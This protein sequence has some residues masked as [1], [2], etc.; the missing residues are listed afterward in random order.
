[1]AAVVSVFSHHAWPSQEMC[2]FLH[3]WLGGPKTVLH[4]AYSP[5]ESLCVSLISIRR[6]LPGLLGLRSRTYQALPHWRPSILLGCHKSMTI[7]HSD[8]T[9]HF[10]ARI[11]NVQSS[12]IMRRSSMSSA[13]SARCSYWSWSFSP[14]SISASFSP[15]QS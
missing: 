4:C 13:K 5:C 10:S 3:Q 11:F 14:C 8:I 12:R 1:M 6:I 9:S 2:I 15:F 7:V